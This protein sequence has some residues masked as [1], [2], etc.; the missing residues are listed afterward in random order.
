MRGIERLKSEYRFEEALERAT[1]ALT[2]AE[3][4]LGDQ[5]RIGTSLHSMA[6]V[7][8]VT[9][10]LA[11]AESL[12]RRAQAALGQLRLSYLDSIHPRKRMEA[13][14]LRA[15][16]LNNIAIIFMNIGEIKSSMECVAESVEIQVAARSSW[17]KFFLGAAR[18]HFQTTFAGTLSVATAIYR[19][20][21]NH[22]AAEVFGRRALDLLREI[23]SERGPEFAVC[24]ISLARLNLEIGNR[25][26]AEQLVTQAIRICRD[27]PKHLD[28]CL[29][30]GLSN[31]ARIYGSMGRSGLA[32]PL[33][34]EALG[35]YRRLLGP[36][37][38]N[39][40][41]VSIALA[42]CHAANA[43]AWDALALMEQAAGIHDRVMGQIFSFVSGRQREAFLNTIRNDFE[44]FLSLVV[45]QLRG[46]APAIGA[47]F[48]L[49]LKRKVLGGEVALAQWETVLGG[50]YPALKTRLHDLAAL[51]MQI[52]RMLLTSQKR[53]TLTEDQKKLAHLDGLKESLEADLARQIPEM[54]LERKL[55]SSDRQ[56][57]ACGIPEDGVLVEFVRCR[58]FDFRAVPSRGESEWKPA[59]YL[60]F[61]LP[62]GGAD[63]VQLIDL[64][65]AEPIDRLITDY[66]AS[67]TGET[68]DSA[69]RDL[70]RR[71]AETIPVAH[72][73]GTLLRAAV[74][75]PISSALG[76]RR[77][78]LLAPDGEL[79]RLP[80]EVLPTGKCNNLVDN[81]IITYVSSARD[82]IRFGARPSG[83]PAESLL[84][85]DPDFDL[86]SSDSRP[87]DR[88]S[89]HP[90]LGQHGAAPGFRSSA[91]ASS[92]SDARANWEKAQLRRS[93]S[94]VSRDL[95]RDRCWF[96]RLPGSRLEGQ[97]IARLL[98]IQPWLDRSALEGRLKAECHS[99]LILHVATHSFFLEDQ[100]REPLFEHHPLDLLAI[101]TSPIH[102]RDLL[103]LEDPMLRCGLALAGA[104]TWLRDGSLPA[105]AEDG[106]L[107]AEDV[108]GLDLHAT[109]MVVLSACETGLG[110]VRTGE[111][112]LG[113][114]RAFVLSGAKTL[115]MSLWRV[116]DEP[117]QHLM[118]LFYLRILSGQSRAEAMREAQLAM[119]S[120]YLAPYYWGAFICQ[121]D[122]SPLAVRG[123][124][125]ASESELEERDNLR[126][127]KP[128]D[129]P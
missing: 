89:R 92:G 42:K 14:F 63:D 6:E 114:R 117:T 109:E 54:S 104:N 113:L 17:G 52:V 122:P 53:G 111:G 101:P 11:A 19:L 9:G 13:Q 115:V 49:V 18:R 38:V 25:A 97:R 23:R 46:A 77:R 12:C 103:L 62:A 37:H 116:P 106:L 121:G 3:T 99:P 87:C 72:D 73:P 68:E 74:F 35:L 2:L 82:V 105:E 26:A 108:S 84:I 127:G 91:A 126:V 32:E 71:R 10:D 44:V 55:R 69:G 1:G 90:P 60:A 21:G 102:P 16:I 96:S 79:N 50:K 28:L 100:R 70:G 20:G 88:F 40:A 29:A 118:E 67:I 41:T 80:F 59:R 65:E 112:V 85:A 94:G 124:N 58:I 61:V 24:L 8:A 81:Y 125:V 75:D 22:A 93:L 110:E 57:V 86:D 51:R 56:A 83:E 120:R 66:R 123:V 128:S 33:L 47:A 39:V 48:D 129:Q 4:Y 30:A 31:L 45:E 107:T 76:D 98:G 95:D 34:S 15:H 7:Y 64:G 78:V 27:D 43:R 36:N 5:L 119:R